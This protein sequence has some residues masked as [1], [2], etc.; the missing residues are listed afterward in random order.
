MMKLARPILI[1]TLLSTAITLGACSGDSP[2]ERASAT[3][4]EDFWLNATTQTVQMQDNRFYPSVLQ[5]TSAQ[6]TRL[7]LV[8]NGDRPHAFAAPQFFQAIRIGHLR[9]ADGMIERPEAIEQ[10]RLQPDETLEFYFVP[11]TPGRYQLSG[12]GSEGTIVVGTRW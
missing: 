12:N 4:P 8:N 9:D 1:S 6:P 11:E 5:L 10:I 3:L 7:I 2:G